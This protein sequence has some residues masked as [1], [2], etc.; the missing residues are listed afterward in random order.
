M[1]ERD[2]T[3][4]CQKEKPADWTGKSKIWKSGPWETQTAEEEKAC[5]GYK[6]YFAWEDKEEEVESEVASALE[7]AWIMD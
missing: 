3:P 6:S 1:T 4:D 7:L 2:A 5:K